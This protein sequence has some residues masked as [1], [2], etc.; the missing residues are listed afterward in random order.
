MIIF[1]IQLKE[2]FKEW[3]NHINKKELIEI[4]NFLN[5]EYKIKKISPDK[6]DIFKIFSLC[7]Y[8]KLKVVIIG[9]DPYP[10]AKK[11]TGIMFG[12]NCEPLSPSL[13][14]IKETILDYTNPE[15][16]YREFD[17]TLE[18]WANQGVLLLNSS[19]TVEENKIGSHI[20][21][22]RRFMSSFIESL[23]E[24]NSSVIFIL[25]GDTAKTFKSY[26]HKDC[27]VLQEKH[28]AYYIRMNK[29]MPDTV[30]KTTNY[31]LEKQYKTNIKWFNE[32][33]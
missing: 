25:F 4:I 24:A 20:N 15:H 31:I 9:Q 7:D 18:S 14:V 8:S 17:I 5:N 23:S 12:N 13:E 27:I 1:L 28:P 32:M 2:Y 16:I 11:A 22:W 19:L 26:I 33:K 30:F 29:K 21:L 6:G 3:Y 10:Q